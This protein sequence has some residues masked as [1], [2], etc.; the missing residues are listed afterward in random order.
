MQQ[1]P[2]NVKFLVFSG[3]TWKGMTHNQ[4]DI[5]WCKENLKDDRF[6]FCEGNNDMQDFAIMKSCDHNIVSHSTS[7]GYW[8][9]FLNENPDKIIVAP[10]T[11][12]VPPDGRVKNGFY[13]PSWRIV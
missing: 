10:E 6:I 4:G 7:F 13:P 12:A 2:E 1:F 5:N 3:G 11:Y 9:A 8:A